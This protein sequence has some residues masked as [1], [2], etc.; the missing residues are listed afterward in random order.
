MATVYYEDYIAEDTEKYDESQDED[1]K[2]D[3]GPQDEEASSSSDEDNAPAK[4]TSRSTK[5]K[6]P[7]DDDLDSGDEV[8]IQAA[9]KKKSKKQKKGKKGD[10]DEDVLLSEGEGGLIKTRAQRRVEQVEKKP[11]A[12]TEGATVDVD[13][14]WA[15]M[16]AAPLKPIQPVEPDHPKPTTTTAPTPAPKPL[17]AE[18]EEQIQ[19]KK[20]YTFAGQD[21]T[22]EKSIPRSHLD[23][24]TS[25]GWTTL[26]EP[27]KPEKTKANT[28]KIRR[29]LRRPSRFD[30]NPTGYVRALA[31]E[32]QLTYPRTTTSTTTRTDMPPPE[33]PA[34]KAKAQKLNVVDKSRMDWTGF[35]DKEGIAE[36]LDTHGKTKEAYLG[37]MEFLKEV[38]A[39]RE[40]ERK[41]V[42]VAGMGVG[43]GPA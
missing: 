37:R 12:R 16:T 33:L 26:Q 29:P 8:T 17:P 22:E 14:L 43:G 35:V 23:K 38:E 7:V 4:P 11:L 6:A 40:E 25:D 28:S 31:P 36:E 42:R 1:F 34:A 24:Y 10:D 39:R 41:K 9:R 21:T 2:P 30:P 5:R 13:A 27:T 32:H 18:E 19:I 20:T 15:Q 3:D